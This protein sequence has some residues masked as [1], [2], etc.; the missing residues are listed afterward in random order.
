[1][2]CFF[3]DGLYMFKLR[4]LSHKNEKNYVHPGILDFI[5]HVNIILWLKLN[6]QESK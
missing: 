6:S 1:M 3:S 5:D 4:H 2:L